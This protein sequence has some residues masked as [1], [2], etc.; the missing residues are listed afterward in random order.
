MNTL[1]NLSR[2]IFWVFNIQTH[3][4]PN[5][6]VST[7]RTTP[8][9]SQK[10]DITNIHPTPSFKTI[11]SA[12][13]ASFSV[14]AT[15][16]SRR[17]RA[18]AAVQHCAKG[19]VNSTSP[20]CTARVTATPRPQGKSAKHSDEGKEI[21]AANRK[22]GGRLPRNSSEQGYIMTLE[23]MMWEW[24]GEKGKWWLLKL[25][26]ITVVVCE[27]GEGCFNIPWC[28]EVTNDDTLSP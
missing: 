5:Q 2:Y 11:N 9:K 7:N 24:N 13:M 8:K 14:I 21:M 25:P 20:R 12:M 27:A 6:S 19:T 4:Q 22:S 28:R 17:R 16:T 23:L 15:G 3:H 1:K 10:W 26:W 18:L